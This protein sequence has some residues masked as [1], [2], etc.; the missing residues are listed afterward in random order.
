MKLLVILWALTS[1]VYGK[2]G[3]SSSYSDREENTFA[4]G[5][6]VMP[7]ARAICRNIDETGGVEIGTISYGACVPFNLREDGSTVLRFNY[8]VLTATSLEDYLWTPHQEVEEGMT[9][10]NGGLEDKIYLCRNR[11]ASPGL[12]YGTV[13]ENKCYYRSNEFTLEYEILIQ[14]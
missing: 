1:M 13:M 5:T 7:P 9:P 12:V 8:E 3:W 11:G 6:N 2:L 4:I 10:F 14:L